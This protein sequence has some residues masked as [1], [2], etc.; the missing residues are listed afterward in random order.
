[1]TITS[2]RIVKTKNLSGAFDGE[3][4]RIYGG[5]WNSKGLSVV[6]TAGSVSLAVLEMLVHETPRLMSSYS[7]ISA[8]FDI[9]VIEEVRVGAL[10]KGWSSYPAPSHVT[11]LGD[12]WLRKKRSA[13]LKVPSAVVATESNYL[14]NPAHADFG[15]IAIGKPLRLPI[16]PR[17]SK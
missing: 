7:V 17:L 5:R 16:D 4:A 13:V 2:W 12:E 14:L 3:G 9:E 1:M 11:K 8:T 15:K 10:T 6:Y